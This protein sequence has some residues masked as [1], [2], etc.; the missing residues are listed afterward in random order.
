MSKSKKNNERPLL[1][2]E[3]IRDGLREYLAVNKLKPGTKKAFATEHA[4]LN[5]L[6]A[7]SDVPPVVPVCMAV[8]RSILT[9]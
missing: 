9:A 8:G 5:G 3:E 7:T 2:V 4:Y 6:M 1:G